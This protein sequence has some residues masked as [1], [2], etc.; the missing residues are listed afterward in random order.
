LKTGVIEK[1]R[2]IAPAN[3][4]HIILEESAV[5]SVAQNQAFLQSR[6]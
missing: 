4:A 3:G 1:A 6:C 5:F 2:L